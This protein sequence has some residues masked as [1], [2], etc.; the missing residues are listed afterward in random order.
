MEPCLRCD[1]DG[2]YVDSESGHAPNCDCDTKM[3]TCPIEVQ[4]Q[5]ECSACGGT[6][7][8]PEAL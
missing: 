3:T 4:V 5:V 1:G 6:G 7:R 8:V 2:W